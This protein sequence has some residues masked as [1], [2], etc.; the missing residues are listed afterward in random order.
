MNP[1]GCTGHHFQE[2]KI[3][4]GLCWICFRKFLSI[5]QTLSLSPPGFTHEHQSLFSHQLLINPNNS[6]LF[7]IQML[8]AFKT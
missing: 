6:L 1:D 4:K 5:F 2:G 8:P 7:L 3:Q